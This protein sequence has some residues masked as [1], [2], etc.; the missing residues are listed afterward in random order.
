[1]YNL[2]QLVC[3][4]GNICSWSFSYCI[5]SLG[6]RSSRG[7]QDRL[8]HCLSSPLCVVFSLLAS[9]SRK[10]C[11]SLPGGSYHGRHSLFSWHWSSY[12]VKT[13]SNSLQIAGGAPKSHHHYVGTL[14][15]GG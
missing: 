9:A 8:L 4:S 13:S 1:M 14:S 11:F 5:G 15:N 7:F 10:L 6:I 3:R 2:C 12:I